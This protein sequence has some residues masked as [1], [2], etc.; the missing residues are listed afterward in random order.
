MKA[1]KVFSL[2]A[3]IVSVTVF[4]GDYNLADPHKVING[5]FP[6]I[7]NPSG[8]GDPADRAAVLLAMGAKDTPFP[9]DLST[10]SD[11]VNTIGM[12][13][14]GL[15][16]FM[17][18]YTNKTLITTLKMPDGSAMLCFDNPISAME[19]YIEI[20][21]KDE[22]LGASL[23][24][25]AWQY[26]GDGDYRINGS[27]QLDP[28]KIPFSG[29]H[30]LV[31]YQEA[32]GDGNGVKTGWINMWNSNAGQNNLKDAVSPKPDGGGV[33]AFMTKSDPQPTGPDNSYFATAYCLAP[34]GPGPAP[35][36]GRLPYGKMEPSK[37][38]NLFAIP[39]AS[40]S[41]LSKSNIFGVTWQACTEQ[42]AIAIMKKVCG[43]IAGAK[44][45][46][47]SCQCGDLSIGPAMMTGSQFLNCSPG[48][49]R[50]LCT[51][52]VAAAANP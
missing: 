23:R 45:D 41:G 30:F 36:C 1:H 39:T 12:G 27:N 3:G 14:V 40:V 34:I 28:K 44:F 18:G 22:T 38:D 21:K 35:R 37:K 25:L 10:V 49:L 15:A 4:A 48:Q 43:E 29:Y 46:M 20:R 8:K 17:L 47:N 11:D 52:E 13:C 24:I 42:K 9:A 50:D 2:I 51:K 7:Q 31:W 33:V 6:Y 32:A 5:T 16:T 26:S 19:K